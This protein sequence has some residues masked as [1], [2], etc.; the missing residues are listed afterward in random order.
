MF[1]RVG[2]VRAG[3][4]WQMSEAHVDVTVRVAAEDGDRA[5]KVLRGAAF[6]DVR[7]LNARRTRRH[8]TWTIAEVHDETAAAAGR[9]RLRIGD[10]EASLAVLGISFGWATHGIGVGSISSAWLNVFFV[11]TQKPTGFKV[12]VATKFESNKNSPEWLISFE[13][14]PLTSPCFLSPRGCTID[15][16]IRD[17]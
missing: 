8:E 15:P 5:I 6:R 14:I 16:A 9:E 7:V 10:V 17:V 13:A 2:A 11:S 4:Q 1:A 3:G 12:S